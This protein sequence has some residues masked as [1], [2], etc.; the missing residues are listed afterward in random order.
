MNYDIV[1]LV[2]REVY[3]FPIHHKSIAFANVS[4]SLNGFWKRFLSNN[5]ICNIIK[6][7]NISRGFWRLDAFPLT[8]DLQLKWTETSGLL[9]YQCNIGMPTAHSLSNRNYFQRQRFFSQ[10]EQHSKDSSD[11]VRNHFIIIYLL[12]T[13]FWRILFVPLL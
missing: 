7:Y 8:S 13:A 3:R 2:C 4:L 12:I 1:E 11:Q 5:R 6:Y 9:Q 10:A